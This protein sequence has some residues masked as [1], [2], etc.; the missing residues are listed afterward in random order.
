M[1]TPS[2]MEPS[3]E[4]LGGG[5]DWGQL[6]ILGNDIALQWYTMLH[7]RDMPQ[8]QYLPGTGIPTAV[9]Q[10]TTQLLIVLAVVGA[11]VLV[12]RK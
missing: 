9:Y 6:A 8:P 2:M 11:I 7:D 5:F 4:G 12:M 1:V 10:Q 3:G